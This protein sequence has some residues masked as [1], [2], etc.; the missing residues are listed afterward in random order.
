MPMLTTSFL[1]CKM[2][3]IL[4]LVSA[5]LEF[6]VDRNSAQLGAYVLAELFTL[7]FRCISYRSEISHSPATRSKTPF[8]FSYSQIWEELVFACFFLH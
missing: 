3:T 7:V 1:R 8:V 4:I 6:Q 2:D 5:L